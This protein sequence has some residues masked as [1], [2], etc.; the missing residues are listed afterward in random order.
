[1]RPD[2]PVTMSDSRGRAR[3]LCATYAAAGDALGWFEALYREA[4]AGDAVVPWADLEP[5]PH[6][7]EWQR[8]AAYDFQGKRC[9][10]VGCGLGDD[11]E[12]LAAAGGDVVAFDV[13]GTAIE[14]CRMRFSGSPV[15]YVEADVLVPRL[16]WDRRFDFVFEAYTLQVLPVELRQRVLAHLAGMLAPD[17]TLLVVSRGRDVSEPL[18]SMPWPLTREELV[19]ESTLELVTFEDYF[20]AERPPVRRFRAVFQRAA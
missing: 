9:L 13:A 15:E 2:A 1:M 8:R 6:L 14:W 17:G 12:Y 19:K 7:C 18:G 16:E 4:S 20:D 3:E 5:N 10:T 11:A